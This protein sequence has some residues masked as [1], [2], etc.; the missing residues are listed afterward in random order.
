MIASTFVIVAAILGLVVALV[1]MR[2]PDGTSS[3]VERAYRLLLAVVGGGLLITALVLEIEL[4]G[5]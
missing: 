2:A 1:R 5:R 3:R 4:G